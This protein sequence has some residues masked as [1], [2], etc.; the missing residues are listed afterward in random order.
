MSLGSNESIYVKVE[1]FGWFDVVYFC[2]I[3]NWKFFNLF[4]DLYI[5]DGF[6][7]YVILVRNNI[8]RR[9]NIFYCI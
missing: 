1:V 8:K 5:L 9:K 6:D 3:L 4:I 7:K 2:D